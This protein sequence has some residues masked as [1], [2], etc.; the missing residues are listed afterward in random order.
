[1]RTHRGQGLE[2]A[3]LLVEIAD[4]ERLLLL[5]DPARRDSVHGKGGAGAQRPRCG[6]FQRMETE[7]VL[8]GIV[9]ITPR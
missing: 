2:K 9:S 3:G 8:R 5:P 7:H 1:M 6:A 4:D